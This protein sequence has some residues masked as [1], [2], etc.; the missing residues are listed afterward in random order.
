MSLGTSS[1]ILAVFNDGGAATGIGSAI[2]VVSHPDYLGFGI[3]GPGDAS[4]LTSQ[5]S[6]DD[7]A[8]ITLGEDVPAG[9]EI[10]DFYTGN[11][12]GGELFTMVGHGTTGNGVDGFTAG[13][14]FFNKR[15]GFNN[16]ELFGCDDA[17]FGGAFSVPLCE[18]NGSDTEVWYADF[19]GVDSF[20][21]FDLFCI[22]LVNPICDAGLGSD[23]TTGLF[24]ASIGRGD[25]G[26]PSFVY[27][28][29]QDKFLLAA[30][31]TFG[32]QVIA[33]NA[34]GYGEYFGGNIYRPYIDW[35]SSVISASS[36]V[37]GPSSIGLLLV[38]LIFVVRRRRR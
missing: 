32:S 9:V 29:V 28:A 30:N 27:D 37:S 31:N 22:A 34:G 21:L 18:A 16:A 23:T 13:S 33:E 12:S 24:E 19:D 38:G 25:S 35:V 1:E 20:G 15:F 26:G 17:N 7:I 36:A 6:N 14:D 10:Y 2:N 8:I 3:C 4:G 5:C 11:L